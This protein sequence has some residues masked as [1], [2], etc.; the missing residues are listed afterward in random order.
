MRA[1]DGDDWRGGRGG[2]DHRVF[3]PGNIVVTRSVYTGDA[4]TV[5]VGQTLPPFCVAGTVNVPLLAGGTVSVAVTCS[6]ATNDGTF[7]TIFNN[8]AADGSFGVTSP[9]FLD[10]MT[11]D[12]HLLS[13]SR[14]TPHA[15]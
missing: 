6:T 9:I 8:G 15:S 5:T 1:H 7:P 11:D 2:E 12:G 4:S 3:W 13:T 14:S 10:Q